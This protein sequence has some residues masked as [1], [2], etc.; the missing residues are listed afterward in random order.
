MF[1]CG[2]VLCLKRIVFVYGS[3]HRLSSVVKVKVARIYA[4]SYKKKP[5]L[6]TVILSKKG[7]K[8]K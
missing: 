4:E 3:L 1:V 5:N 7:K 2:S 6:I 8:E